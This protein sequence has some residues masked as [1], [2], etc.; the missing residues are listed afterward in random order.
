MSEISNE[1]IDRG[2]ELHDSWIEEIKLL[3][4]LSE[5]EISFELEMDGWILVFPNFNQK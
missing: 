2:G 4:S 5:I 1:H 3:L